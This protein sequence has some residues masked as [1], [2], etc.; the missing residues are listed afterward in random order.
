MSD[1]VYEQIVAGAEN[2]LA[3]R[4]ESARIYVMVLV[5]LESWEVPSA[6]YGPGM[7]CTDK[8][9][10]DPHKRVTSWKVE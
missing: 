5:L 9:R 8:D 2:E 3:E 7:L 10:D 1:V 6:D 4:G